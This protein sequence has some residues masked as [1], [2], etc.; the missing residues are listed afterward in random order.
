MVYLQMVIAEFSL[1]F[2]GYEFWVLQRTAG[3]HEDIDGH[4]SRLS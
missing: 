4:H 1:Q 2:H 3:L